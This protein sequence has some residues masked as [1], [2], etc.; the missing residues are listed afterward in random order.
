M[1][2]KLDVEEMRKYINICKETNNEAKEIN[3]K[4]W[5]NKKYL[6]CN[7]GHTIDCKINENDEVIA[8]IGSITSNNIEVV[9]PECVEKVKEKYIK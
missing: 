5:L 3:Y 6:T 1:T 2:E 4:D 7:N 8:E 9:C